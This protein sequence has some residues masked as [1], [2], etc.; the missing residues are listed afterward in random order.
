MCTRTTQGATSSRTGIR[1][2]RRTSSAADQGLL[3][4]NAFSAAPVCSPSRAALLTGRWPHCNGMVGLG[5]HPRLRARLSAPAPIARC[6]T[7]ATG[8]RWWGSSTSAYLAELGYD[9]IGEARTTTVTYV[10]PAAVSIIRERPREPFFL[11]VGFFET[12][13]DYFEPTSVRDALDPVPPV[14]LPDTHVTRDMAAFKQSVLAR[15]RTSA[16]C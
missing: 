10:G 5:A 8:R 12:H 6:A 2:S 9:L 7:P 11:S 3:F 4:R 13:R 16:R 1:W 15:P 14:N